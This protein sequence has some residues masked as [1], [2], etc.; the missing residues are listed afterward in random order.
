MAIHTAWPDARPETL[1]DMGYRDEECSNPECEYVG[2]MEIIGY[3]SRDEFELEC[4]KCG[5]P[6]YSRV[7]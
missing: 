1:D 2:D 7:G 6:T 3:P 4:P 5:L